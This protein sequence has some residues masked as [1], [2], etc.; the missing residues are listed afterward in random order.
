MDLCSV[1]P[2]SPYSSSTFTQPITKEDMNSNLQTPP[3]NCHWLVSNYELGH[4]V[5][6][7]AEVEYRARSHYPNDVVGLQNI[8]VY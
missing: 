6:I 3:T 2:G 1:I 7:Q 4:G 8:G 5:G